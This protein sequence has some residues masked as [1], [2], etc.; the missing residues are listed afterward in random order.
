MPITNIDIDLKITGEVTNYKA[1]R[2]LIEL[3]LKL[4]IFSKLIKV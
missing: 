3:W 4:L 1:I 2:V